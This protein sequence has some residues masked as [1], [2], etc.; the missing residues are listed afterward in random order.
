LLGAVAAQQKATRGFDADCLLSGKV[1][2]GHALPLAAN[3]QPGVP[4]PLSF[5]SDKHGDQNLV[6]GSAQDADFWTQSARDGRQLQSK[7]S[8]YLAKG[9]LFTV[10]KRRKARTAIDPAK[11]GRSADGQFFAFEAIAAR[12][13]FAFRVAADDPAHLAEVT[14]ILTGGGIRLGRSH[15][16]EYGAVE[17]TLLESAPA[18]LADGFAHPAG[19]EIAAIFLLSDF[20]PPPGADPMRPRPEWFGMPE[21][22]AWL[23]ERTFLRTRSFSPW[24]AHHRHLDRGRQVLVRGSVLTFAL[25]AGADVAALAAGLRHGAGLYRNEGFGCV[26]VNPAFLCQPPQT[27]EKTTPLQ[28]AE[29]LPAGSETPLVRHFRERAARWS[30]EL[31]ARKAGEAL[32][33]RIR[34]HLERLERPPSKSQWS[35]IRALAL[36]RHETTAGLREALCLYCTG[37]RTRGG[38]REQRSV[39]HDWWTRPISHGRDTTLHATLDDALK[40]RP[41][42]LAARTL[43]HTARLVREDQE[44]RQEPS[45]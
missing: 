32:A 4:V 33:S 40:D 3:G 19:P 9:E 37:C 29:T 11:R 45:R 36:Q 18:D 30:A 35:E 8:G 41:P 31:S 13:R 38:E 7:K 26:L 1:R 27:L 2:F 15:G 25:P 5:H 16:T 6:E 23:S 28:V 34:R 21:G 44:R 39:R 43:Y 42:A 10:K 12:Q 24:N 22:T 14:R 20:A 17:I